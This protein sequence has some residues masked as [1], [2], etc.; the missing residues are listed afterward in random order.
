MIRSPSLRRLVFPLVL[1]GLTVSLG[2]CATGTLV[3]S[4]TYAAGSAYAAPLGR[5][6]SDVTRM[7]PDLQRNVKL[8][9]VDGPVLNQLYLA[10]DIPVGQGLFRP[11][12]RRQNQARQPVLAADATR[13]DLADFLAETLQAL[14][15]QGVEATA[16]RPATFGGRPAIEAEFAGRT[17]TGLN[18][19]A[20]ALAAVQDGKLQLILFIAPQEHYFDAYR[21]EIT[22][23]FAALN[24]PA[25][26]PA[27]PAPAPAAAEPAPAAP[28]EAPPAATPVPVPTP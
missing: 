13:L 20:R 10:H 4:G 6:W 22:G 9:T 12:A 2:A 16:T 18:M 25:P 17:E 24:P 14:G 26:A 3:Q 5:T 28:M 11:A 15:L 27:A 19:S 21:T 7:R 23:M 8:L 1:T